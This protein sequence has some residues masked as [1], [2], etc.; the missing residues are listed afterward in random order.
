MLNTISH[1]EV[2]INTSV[3]QPCTP[4]AM[5]IMRKAHSRGSREAA[6]TA[7]TLWMGLSIV[8][9]LWQTVWLFLKKLDV[10]SSWDPATLTLAI[11]PRETEI[12]VYTK[13]CMGMFIAIFFITA[14][15]GKQFGSTSAS[16]WINKV[17]TIHIIEHYLAIKHEAL[18]HTPAWL[19]PGNTTLSDSSKAPKATQYVIPFT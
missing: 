13:T 14:P 2:R 15:Q 9:P 12:Y 7:Q 16:N 4:T 19:S 5:T 18:P 17:Y 6:G 8:L 1:Q 11:Y 10:N 3:K